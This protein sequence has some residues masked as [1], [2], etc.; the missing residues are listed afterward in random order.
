MFVQPF[1]GLLRGTS[2]GPRKPTSDARFC[3]EVWRAIACIL[4]LRPD[5]LAIPLRQLVPTVGTIATY[6]LI[7]D[8]G[9]E[10][11]G[12]ALFRIGPD[13]NP[14]L[15]QCLCYTDFPTSGWDEITRDP[16]YQNTREYCGAVLGIIMTLDAQASG[17]IPPGPVHL[18]WHGDNTSALSWI[19]QNRM[20]S[21]QTQRIFMAYTCLRMRVPIDIPWTSHKP[22][23][24][25]GDIDRLSRRQTLRDLPQEQRVEFHNRE[26]LEALFSHID[27]A[28]HNLGTAGDHHD[29]FLTIYL[30]VARLLAPQ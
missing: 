6:G 1:N 18:H 12:I 11:V 2:P 15:A 19:D 5:D 4:A 25:M 8:A 22:G 24:D 3:V 16:R 26:S 27:P 7:T 21:A 28:A 9:P 20:R 17:L 10:C 14:D 29:A 30:L 13:G 23:V